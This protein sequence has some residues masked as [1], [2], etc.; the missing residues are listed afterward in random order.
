MFY[1]VRNQDE[2]RSVLLRPFQDA[3]KTENE[4]KSLAEDPERRQNIFA[5][6]MAEVK[7]LGD[8]SDK[9]TCY[10]LVFLPMLT[11]FLRDRGIF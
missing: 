3:F 7:G 9:G 1:I 2:E 11:L 4:K 10:S 8:G 5:M 6:V